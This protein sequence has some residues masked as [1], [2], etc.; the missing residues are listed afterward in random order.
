MSQF[1]LKEI[2]IN[3]I[4]FEKNNGLVPV[5]V[6]EFKTRKILMLAYMNKLALEK[7][8]ETGYAFYW[9]RSRKK[10]WMK[11]ETSGNFQKVKRIIV[12]CDNDTI[13]LI[14]EQI[15]NACHENEKSCF[16]NKILEANSLEERTNKEF[17]KTILEYF[18]NAYIVKMPWAGRNKEKGYIYIVNPIT[19][20]IP[21]PE[22]E[23]LEWIAELIDKIASN[24]FDKV[25]TIE[26]L[27]IPMATL[28]ANIKGKPLAIVRK[29]VFHESTMEIPSIEYTSGFESGK[30][31]LYGVKEGE[32]VLI[33]DD[34]VSTG[35]TL[36][37]LIKLLNNLKIKI[38]DVICTVEK[39]DYGGA[40]A[41]EE[42]T[43]INIKT[44]FQVFIKNGKIFAR[45]NP[46][47]LELI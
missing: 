34:M 19:E 43:G 5:I 39:P 26:A 22:P 9:S 13:L 21:P 7:T 24:D 16:H 23:I 30:Y 31:Y 29:R 8:L 46:K 11:G 17:L 44:I 12:D 32:S 6:Q 47:I 25:L 1:V 15:G 4:N 10:I 45:I 40:K 27:G 33:I 35:G 37:S 20:H 41:V 42:E 28:V 18:K 14:V 36:I 38:V 2:K 3:E